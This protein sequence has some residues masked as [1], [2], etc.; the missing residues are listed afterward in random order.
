MQL[1]RAAGIAAAVANPRATSRTSGP[2]RV[3][4]QAYPFTVV[5]RPEQILDGQDLPDGARITA[6][7]ASLAVAP[8]PAAPDCAYS[9]CYRG[10]VPL[11]ARI[12][13]DGQRREVSI[14]VVDRSRTEGVVL[15]SAGLV[16]RKDD[17]TFASGLLTTYSVTKPSTA[18]AVAAL[19]ADVLKACFGAIS[20][21]LT[22]R[23]TN[24]TAAAD[25]A[26]QQARLLL[27]QQAVIEAQRGLDAARAGESAV[28]G[29][30]RAPS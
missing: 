18:L 24:Q 7:P 23:V 3:R 28:A 16:E 29:P 4:A 5:L 21:L 25:L 15:R 22:I 14:A 11:V 26:Q 10:V 30:G 6:G 1:A 13:L 20:E 2:G 12:S 27:Q 19:P 8:P 17:M 9:L